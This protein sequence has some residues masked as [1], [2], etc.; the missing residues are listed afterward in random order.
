VPQDFPS[1][2][3]LELALK[4]ALHNL[5]FAD[6]HLISVD[7]NE[8]AITHRLGH[9]LQILLPLWH[10]DCEY[11]RDGHEPKVTYLEPR[12][13]STADTEG[14][15]VF[16]DIIVHRRGTKQNLLIIEVKKS[17]NKLPIEDD[18]TKLDSYLR[19]PLS[20]AYAVHLVIRTDDSISTPHRINWRQL[21]VA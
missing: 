13:T 15:T 14:D 2:D 1:L 11:N 21:Q 12:T 5:R 17:S 7:A 19:P 18:L 8:R 16:P 9:H 6:G 4:L 10:V 20:Y 3:E